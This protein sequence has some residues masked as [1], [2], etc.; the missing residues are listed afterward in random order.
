MA[1]TATKRRGWLSAAATAG[2]AALSASGAKAEV[3]RQSEI[4]FRIEQSIIVAASPNDA[5]AMLI[6]PAAWWSP[7]HTY[8]GDARNLR[9]RAKVGGCWCETWEANAVRHLA[10][11]S[12][13]PGSSLVMEGGLGPLQAMGVNGVMT[14]MIAPEG[15]G[16]RISLTYTVGGFFDPPVEAIAP[17]VDGVLGEQMSNLAAKLG[18]D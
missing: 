16:T 7:A 11:I 8:S 2:L 3:V 5:W 13:M 6:A 1:N 17:A 18:G 9:L 15:E 12:V 14:F 4:G 10:V